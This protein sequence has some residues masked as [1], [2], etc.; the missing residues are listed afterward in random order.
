MVKVA[1]RGR[2]SVYVHREIGQPHHRPH[3]HVRWSEDEV[4]VTV[5]DAELLAGQ[6]LPAAA[7]ELVNDSMP[8]ITAAWNRLNP[9]RPVQ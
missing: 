4:R 3:C 5:P 6:K 8:D 9:E 1:Q 7:R 2:F